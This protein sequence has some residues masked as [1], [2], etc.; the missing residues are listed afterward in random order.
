MHALARNPIRQVF[1]VAL[2]TFMVFMVALGLAAWDLP[3]ASQRARGNTDFDSG[4]YPEAIEHY[5]RAVEHG[6][7]DWETHHN[8]G[9]AYYRQGEWEQAVEELEYAVQ[10]ADSAGTQ[11]TDLAR[12]YHNLGL[13]YIQLDDCANAVPSFNSAAELA[14]EDEDIQRNL[15]FANEYCASEGEDAPQTEGECED[16]G[17]GDEEDEEQGQSSEGESNDESEAQDES[18]CD[19]G[20]QEGEGGSDQDSENQGDEGETED[21][22]EEEGQDGEGDTEE[23]QGEEGEGEEETE[24]SGE[25]DRDSDENA[26]QEGDQ[27]DED[28]D[29]GGEEEDDRNE[30]SQSDEDDREG[31]GNTGRRGPNEIPDDGLG[32]SDSQIEEL[33][34][35]WLNRERSYAPRYFR[36]NP[37]DGDFLDDDTLY[38]L[39]RRLF[40]GLP[41]EDA[42]EI[43]DDGIDW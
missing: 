15:E 43:P 37:Q 12:V 24:E 20:D 35:Y 14:P 4:K 6:S 3:F 9:T 30:G 27:G 11:E 10:L 38:D 7:D 39:F 13:A 8:L 28:S 40:L 32:L 31:G 22:S 18:E 42:R 34:Q 23:D 29:Q 17:E 41:S 2:K 16:E 26:D 5:T 21:Q 19:Q 36:N 33:L 1:L 25:G